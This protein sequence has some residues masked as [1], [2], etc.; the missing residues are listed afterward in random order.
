MIRPSYICICSL[1]QY[2][3]VMICVN[4]GNNWRMI[5]RTGFL[6]SC[7][8]NLL[9]RAQPSASPSSSNCAY[10]SSASYPNEWNFRL[11]SNNITVGVLRDTSLLDQLWFVITRIGSDLNENAYPLYVVP[12]S[13]ATTSNRHEVDMT[14]FSSCKNKWHYIDIL[15]HADQFLQTVSIF[16]IVS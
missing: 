2:F 12:K 13:I 9:N 11:V 15:L 7:I 5:K 3:A 10:F 14:G 6:Y 8:L 1:G 4:M 16:F